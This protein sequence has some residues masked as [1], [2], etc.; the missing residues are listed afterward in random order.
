[1]TD[2]NICEQFLINPRVNPRN[3]KTITKG[4]SMYNSL[5]ED[6]KRKG[7]SVPSELPPLPSFETMECKD[8]INVMGKIIF[9]NLY[10]AHD[11]YINSIW[12]DINN[13]YKYKMLPG[14]RE[15]KYRAM[16]EVKHMIRSTYTHTLETLMKKPFVTID[17]WAF[18]IK[19]WTTNTLQS[20]DLLR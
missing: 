13:K 3:G 15:D 7:Y 16:N 20:I 9:E 8:Y 17:E 2:N 19:N 1:M 4:D 6:C 14:A 10:K 18:E 12:T 11:E 5:L